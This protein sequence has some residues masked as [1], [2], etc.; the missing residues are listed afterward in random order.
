MGIRRSAA[1]IPV[2]DD[3]TEDVRV[4][5]LLVIGNLRTENTRLIVENRELRRRLQ[6]AAEMWRPPSAVLQ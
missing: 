5:L 4:E 3:V 6:L 2:A 1:G